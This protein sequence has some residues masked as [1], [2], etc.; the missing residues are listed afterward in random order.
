MKKLLSLGILCASLIAAPLAAHATE[1]DGSIGVGLNFPGSGAT[2][3]A[4]VTSFSWLGGQTQAGNQ[5]YSSIPVG[6]IVS[7][8][9]TAFL[10]AGHLGGSASNGSTPFTF[11]LG[12]YGTFTASADAV[13]LFQDANDLN[14]TIDGTFT[15]LGA[16]ATDG[17]TT[18][19]A[20]MHFAIQRS[21]GTYGGTYSFT[22]P[23]GFVAPTVPEPS[24]L[25]LLGTGLLGSV[26][27]MRR[28]FKA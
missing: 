16:L 28:R 7:G 21:G 8:N 14:F 1:I 27:A 11:S 5:D 9:T 18:T 26:G 3:L 19:T 24:S 25:I 15:P 4:S 23:I 10:G 13:V 20:D 17:F 12:T 6:T 2:S 22:S